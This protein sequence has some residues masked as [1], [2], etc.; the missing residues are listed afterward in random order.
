MR[1]VNP[2]VPP[3][4]PQPPAERR[5]FWFETPPDRPVGGGGNT[6]YVRPAPASAVEPWLPCDHC[7][8]MGPDCVCRRDL[9]EE[10][11]EALLRISRSR[12]V[13]QRR[14]SATGPLRAQ[15]G[16]AVEGPAA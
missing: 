7:A 14:K 8:G 15:H 10:R 16:A 1:P 5:T 11:W 4:P 9:T 6:V 3:N 12:R 13:R 2:G